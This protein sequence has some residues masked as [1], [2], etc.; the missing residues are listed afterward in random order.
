MPTKIKWKIQ[1]CFILYFNFGKVLL[2]KVIRHSYQ[3]F[4]FLFYISF[5]IRRYNFSQLFGTSFNIIWKNFRR[6]VSF[7]NGFT[8]LHTPNPLNSQNLP[9]VTKAFCQFSLRCPLK[10]FFSKICWQN[11]AK[12]SFMYQQW[13]ATATVF[14]KVPTTDSLVFFSEHIS[15]TAILTQ[16]SV[17]TC[18]YNF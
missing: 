4:Y 2:W 6:K 8:Q 11:P 5:D 3:F 16:A 12:A 13:T 10:H 14:L 1:A 7:F 18:K 15:R 17:I 9:G